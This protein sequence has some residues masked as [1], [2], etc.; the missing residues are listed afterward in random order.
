MNPMD[1]VRIVVVSSHRGSVTH[2]GPLYI[3]LPLAL[4]A[5]ASFIIT[6]PAWGGG[7]GGLFI[8]FL[9]NMTNSKIIS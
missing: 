7:Y 5:A 1:K 2:V 4:G 3:T 8:A 6:Q 9:I